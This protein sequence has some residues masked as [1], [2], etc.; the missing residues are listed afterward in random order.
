MDV[1]NLPRPGELLRY[2]RVRAGGMYQMH[3]PRALKA[4]GMTLQQLINVQCNYG[5]LKE[6]YP[7]IIDKVKREI[8]QGKTPSRRKIQVVVAKKIP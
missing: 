8:E 5:V 2:E 6:M 1:N 3:D 4:C 7:F